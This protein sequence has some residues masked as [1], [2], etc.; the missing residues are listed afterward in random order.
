MT[1]KGIRHQVIW[2]PAQQT[3]PLFLGQT[4]PSYPIGHC[5]SRAAARY[6]IDSEDL[7]FTFLFFTYNLCPSVPNIPQTLNAVSPLPEINDDLSVR[8]VFHEAVN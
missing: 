1:E 4:D 5:I 2:I 8:Q 3:D 7:K 6:Q